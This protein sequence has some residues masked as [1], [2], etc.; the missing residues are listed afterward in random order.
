[1]QRLEAD[2]ALPQPRDDC[3]SASTTIEIRS[4]IELGEAQE[5]YQDAFVQR[6]R[7]QAVVFRPAHFPGGAAAGRKAA[8]EH[9]NLHL[10]HIR[11]G[12]AP[13]LSARR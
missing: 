6:V 7:A 13:N 3:G 11:A 9:V 1:M 5:L 2:P 12:R 8:V 4:W 10:A